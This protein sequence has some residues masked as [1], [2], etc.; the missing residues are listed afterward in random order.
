MQVHGK[1]IFLTEYKE[2]GS[3]DNDIMA[4]DIPLA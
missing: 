4:C 2:N 1:A 3:R